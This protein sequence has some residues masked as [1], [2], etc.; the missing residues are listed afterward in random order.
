MNVFTLKI[1]LFQVSI[2]S[3]FKLELTLE[4]N[5]PYKI[6]CY[7][8]NWAVQRPG[9][10]SMVPEQ[11]D[12]CLCTHLIYAFSE[13]DDN[14]LTPIEKYDH[15]DGDKPGFF[16][17][18]NQLKEINPK[19]KTLLAVGGWDMGMSDFTNMVKTEKNINKFV[20]SSIEY[21]RKWGFDGLDLVNT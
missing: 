12:P 19:L 5:Q 2:L 15:A 7:F 1:I 16:E 20:E 11:I 9:L 17:R 14:K 13:M 6:V 10:A 3:L 8:T 21:L 18:L 4:S